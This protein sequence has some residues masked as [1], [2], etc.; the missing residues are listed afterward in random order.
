MGLGII[1]LGMAVQPHVAALGTMAAQARIVAG[2]S[3]S[4]DRRAAFETTWGLPTVATE[5]ALLAC[6]TY[7]D[8]NPIRAGI[9]ATPEESDFTSIKQGKAGTPT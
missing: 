6:M 5:S 3:P 1:G 8:L 9:A 4:G 7:V 2:F